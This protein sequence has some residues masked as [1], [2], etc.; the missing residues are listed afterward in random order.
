MTSLF[1]PAR[2]CICCERTATPRKRLPGEPNIV[3]VSFVLYYRGAGKRILKA[4]RKVRI[5]ADCLTKALA[6]PR[7]WQGA[8]SRKFVAAIRESL[9][10]RYSDILDEDAL[11][12]VH[13]PAFDGQGNL[14]EG[15]E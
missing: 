5:C 10:E 8:E 14:L 9:S 11:N 13:R 6:E 7:L 2:V 1:K 3:A 15:T 12:Q 4:A